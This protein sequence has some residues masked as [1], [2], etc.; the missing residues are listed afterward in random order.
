M[1]TVNHINNAYAGLHSGRDGVVGGGGCEAKLT[2]QKK[3]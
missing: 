3:S 2:S 1:G